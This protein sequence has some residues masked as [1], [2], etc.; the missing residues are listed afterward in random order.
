MSTTYEFMVTIESDGTVSWFPTKRQAVEY[1]KQSQ[2]P[3]TIHKSKLIAMSHRKEKWTVDLVKE[4]KLQEPTLLKELLTISDSIPEEA[5]DPVL[6]CFIC[7][8]KAI[9]TIDG[10][11][12]CKDCVG[13]E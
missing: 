3:G 11:S 13:E 12:L 9:K 4:P 7:G 10:K 6:K 8:E 1:L 2:A 5:F